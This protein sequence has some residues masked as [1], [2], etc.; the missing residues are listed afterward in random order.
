MCPDGDWEEKISFTNRFS[1][2]GRLE[3]LRLLV[4]AYKCKTSC[5]R[6][7]AWYGFLILLM[8][9]FIGEIANILLLCRGRVVTERM[10]RALTGNMCKYKF[11][12]MCLLGGSPYGVGEGTPFA[13]RVGCWHKAGNE[14][15][16][17]GWN[18]PIDS[19]C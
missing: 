8:G 9:G 19:S 3:G 13:G 2:L 16:F 4:V 7:I 12:C 15:W 17:H 11:F 1:P 18:F 14:D 5:C 10:R 6:C